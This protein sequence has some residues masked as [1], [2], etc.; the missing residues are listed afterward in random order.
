MRLFE[1]QTFENRNYISLDPHTLKTQVRPAIFS[2][3]PT[4]L[5]EQIYSVCHMNNVADFKLPA[6]IVTWIIYAV[7]VAGHFAGVFGHFCW[8]AVCCSSCCHHF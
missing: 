6:C 4:E 7:S 1:S 2:Q 3:M 8:L 5:S